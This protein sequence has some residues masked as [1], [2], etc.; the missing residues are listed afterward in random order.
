MLSELSSAQWGLFTSAQATARGVSRLDLSRLAEAG[1]LERVSHGVY[2][3]AGTS[4][5]EYE[6]LRAAWL[7]IVP[8]V[9][10]SER[11]R[12]L[13]DDAVVSGAS[14]A[15]LH[16]VGDLREDRHEFTSRVRRQ[17]QREG[18]RISTRELEGADVTVRHGLP[19]TTIERTLADLVVDRVD[20]TLV[21][22]VLG[23]AM[24]AGSVSLDALAVR[25]GP[26]AAR[27]GCPA[28]D[29]HALLDRLLRL[30]G[31][32]KQSIA[33]RLAGLESLAFP[34]EMSVFSDL[35]EQSRR[36]QEA[37]R[38]LKLDLPDVSKLVV[39]VDAVAKA[40]QPQV[41]A[42]RPL[43]EQQARLARD[44]QK[45]LERL[46]PSLEAITTVSR[47]AASIHPTAVSEEVPS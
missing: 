5:D 4:D 30:A 27:N 32:D 36:V 9:N 2:R 24:R 46:A 33:G 43:Q 18:V 45:E 17:S 44:W 13:A 3:D 16:G 21:A 34:L 40:F 19:V 6:S 26:L 47:Y 12:S 15:R 22:Q 39:Q 41:E 37:L 29:G 25:L 7:A 11:L 42:M 31:L 1:L 14:A 35:A 8:K 38:G 20:L 23:D 10:A 28:G